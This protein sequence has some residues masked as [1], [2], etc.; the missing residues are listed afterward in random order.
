MTECDKLL[1][2]LIEKQNAGTLKA[3]DRYEIPLQDMPTQDGV[4]RRRNMEEV[5]T[6]YTKTQARLEAMRCLQC[7]NAPCMEGC[8]VRIR[9]RDFV[10]VYRPA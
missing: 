2:E 7:R 6:G 4:E 3:K 10:A 9:I 1:Q 8:P 5:A